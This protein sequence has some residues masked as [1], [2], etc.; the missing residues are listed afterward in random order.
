[1]VLTSCS[2]VPRHWMSVR[3]GQIGVTFGHLEASRNGMTPSRKYL[4]ETKHYNEK[5]RPSLLL[6]LPDSKKDEAQ[7]RQNYMD[8]QPQRTDHRVTVDLVLIL[9]KICPV[10]TILSVYIHCVIF[11]HRIV[12]P[13]WPKTR[14]KWWWFTM[15]VWLKCPEFHEAVMKRL[16]AVLYR[17]R[18]CVGQVWLIF[19]NTLR[20][21]GK[22]RGQAGSDIYC[23]NSLGKQRLDSAHSTC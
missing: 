15:P 3:R 4:K 17:G 2:L 11:N 19:R 5:W 13:F 23:K 14:P 7:R 20:K 10:I 21:T 18:R 16:I 9:P 6:L 22:K 8:P 1:M 12:M